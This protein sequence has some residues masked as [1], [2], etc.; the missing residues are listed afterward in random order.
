MIALLIEN[1][2]DQ[3]AGGPFKPSFGLSGAVLSL[4]KVFLPLVRVFVA[5]IPT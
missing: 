5:S 4:D 3:E 1:R 2:L